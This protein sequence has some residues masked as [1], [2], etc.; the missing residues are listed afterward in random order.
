MCDKTLKSGE[1][2]DF[3]VE[4]ANAIRKINTASTQTLTIVA[5][6]EYMNQAIEVYCADNRLD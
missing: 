5:A 3:L 1:S 2:A 4:A 6:I